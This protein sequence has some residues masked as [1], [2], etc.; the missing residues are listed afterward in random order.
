M[1]STPTCRPP[2]PAP[3]RPPPVVR[4]SSRRARF[5]PLQRQGRRRGP[6]RT[7]TQ[8]PVRAI[9]EKKNVGLAW[10]VRQ[11]EMGALL[12]PHHQSP[13][14]NPPPSQT[15]NIEPTSSPSHP[16]PQP[17]SRNPLPSI[18]PSIPTQH[19]RPRVS[20]SVS[21]SVS[22]ESNHPSPDPIP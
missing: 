11:A 22:Q 12:P 20:Q 3:Y 16:L 17:I 7:H 15:S 19:I 2:N 14:P 9:E 1:K 18:H 21:Q 8:M 5:A 6:A 10:K 4:L 13:P